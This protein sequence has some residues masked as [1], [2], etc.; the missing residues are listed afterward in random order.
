MTI[1]RDEYENIQDGERSHL[2]LKK[3]IYWIEF[4]FNHK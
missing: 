1:K 3:T 2:I 4:I